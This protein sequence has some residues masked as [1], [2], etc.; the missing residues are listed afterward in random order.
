MSP[1]GEHIPVAPSTGAY[2]KLKQGL[3]FIL[4]VS[5]FMALTGGHWDVAWHMR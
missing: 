4:L 1:L 2:L 3:V 5:Q